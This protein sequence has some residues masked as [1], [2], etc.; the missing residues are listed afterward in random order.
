M[1]FPT[2]LQ[3]HHYGLKKGHSYGQPFGSWLPLERR[4]RKKQ[5]TKRTTALA[6]N[7]CRERPS[8][9]PCL[10]RSWETSEQQMPLRS[11]IKS[12]LLLM[13]GDQPPALGPQLGSHHN[14]LQ[15][16]MEHIPFA[17]SDF[18]GLEDMLMS[19]QGCVQVTCV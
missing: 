15:S 4:A 6:S 10:P 18:P 17:T 12:V 2:C 9:V 16:R 5:N 19:F 3:G 7:N 14:S 11:K 1:A 8:F 13:G